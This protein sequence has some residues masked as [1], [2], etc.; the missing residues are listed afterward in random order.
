M[1]F[2]K[3]NETAKW[4]LDLESALKDDPD[5]DFRSYNF[6]DELG[7]CGAITYSLYSR[8]SYDVMYDV[9]ITFKGMWYI[10]LIENGKLG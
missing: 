2:F 7:D 4:L 9:K 1:K 6:T 10:W 8:S 5:H 3:H